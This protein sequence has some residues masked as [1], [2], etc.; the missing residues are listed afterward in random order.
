MFGSA[1]SR[2]RTACQAS[3]R[4]CSDR[5]RWGVKGAGEELPFDAKRDPVFASQ[6]LHRQPGYDSSGPL[7][8]FTA[9]AAGDGFE[10]VS[11]DFPV[12]R[13]SRRCQAG[14]AALFL[15]LAQLREQRVRSIEVLTVIA[16]PL[17]AHAPQVR[18]VQ[19]RLDLRGVGAVGELEQG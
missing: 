2:G 19:A 11:H 8:D 13:L 5:S 10:L 17:W 7:V 3:C 15:G 12:H 4:S 9:R 1:A 6:R 14:A 16:S 18:P